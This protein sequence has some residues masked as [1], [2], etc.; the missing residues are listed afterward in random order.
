MNEGVFTLHKWY[1]NLESLECQADP[2]VSQLTDNR[3]AYIQ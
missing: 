3:K 2:R 1:N